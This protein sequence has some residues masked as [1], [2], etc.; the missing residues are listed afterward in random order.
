MGFSIGL[1][2]HWP[3]CGIAS[4]GI[5][6]GQ[7]LGIGVLF[8]LQAIL[9]FSYDFTFFVSAPLLYEHTKI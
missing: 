1:P 5:N 6:N 3:C 9:G 2:P 4:Y 8:H 7:Q